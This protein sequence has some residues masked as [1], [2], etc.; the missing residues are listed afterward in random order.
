[1]ET[2][3][4]VSWCRVSST[5]WTARYCIWIITVFSA[6]TGPDVSS[7]LNKPF[8]HISYALW[9]SS[10]VPFRL[11]A[12]MRVGGS[13][14]GITES[15]AW[16]CYHPKEDILKPNLRFCVPFPC[17]QTLPPFPS[18]IYFFKIFF[19]YVQEFYGS[20]GCRHGLLP[21]VVGGF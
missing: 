21:P 4:A 7:F 9:N 20:S 10:A 15:A 16:R 2:D 6:V 18:H 11:Q 13:E 14:R 5:A 3:F 17:P 8:S 1:M 12:E 19:V